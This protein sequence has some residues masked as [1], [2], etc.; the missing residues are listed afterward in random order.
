[1]KIQTIVLLTAL[2]FSNRI[3]ADT[4]QYIFTTI[5][6]PQASKFSYGGTYLTGI[7]ASGRGVFRA[8]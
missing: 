5:D 4:N 8:Q 3:T 1:M 6:A 2:A 7:S